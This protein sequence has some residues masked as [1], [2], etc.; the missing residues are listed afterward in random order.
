M[1]PKTHFQL[2]LGSLHI[3]QI[4]YLEWT[5]PQNSFQEEFCISRSQAGVSS[6]TQ[7]DSLSLHLRYGWSDTK[8]E[9]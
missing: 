4:S 6:L 5:V 3:W 7:S 2:V 8:F 9:K 1:Y